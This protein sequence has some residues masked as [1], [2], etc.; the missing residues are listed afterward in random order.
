MYVL[1][2]MHNFIWFGT[3]NVHINLINFMPVTAIT[4]ELFDNQGSSFSHFSVYCP[5]NM[6]F[7]KLDHISPFP[8][9]STYL[10]PFF[11]G[12]VK[13]EWSVL[14]NNDDLF[15]KAW[16]GYLLC[17]KAS[18]IL[19]MCGLRHKVWSVSNWITDRVKARC[20]FGWAPGKDFHQEQQRILMVMTQ[21]P[22]GVSLVWW[23][24]I[25]Q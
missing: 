12:C 2:D 25:G 4:A 11:L 3:Y 5:L 7:A 8:I 1:C 15:K 10:V 9:I 16:K 6:S 23:W 17:N 20:Y 24:W 22:A 18:L 14:N 19:T 21:L 13:G